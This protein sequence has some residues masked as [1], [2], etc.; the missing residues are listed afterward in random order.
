MK[1]T[2]IFRRRDVLESGLVVDMV[3]WR[4][5]ALDPDRPSGL[6]YRL[7]AHREGRAL[8]R[9]DNERRKG[10]HKHIGSREEPY[11]FT[12]VEKLIEDF[13]ADVERLGGPSNV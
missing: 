7:Q 9:Y 6:K 10:D 11:R 13:I 5:P 4:L 2:L 8:V 1:A 12:T 3:I